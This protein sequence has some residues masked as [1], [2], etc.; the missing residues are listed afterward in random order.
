M[1][2]SNRGLATT[3]IITL[4]ASQLCA[5]GVRSLVDMFFR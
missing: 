2:L 3:I 4:L 1:K 5:I